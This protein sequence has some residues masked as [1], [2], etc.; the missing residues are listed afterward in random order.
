MPP[1]INRAAV[2]LEIGET[3]RELAKR[4]TKIDQ[5]SG[6]AL[7]TELRQITLTISPLFARLQRVIDNCRAA[8]GS[9]PNYPAVRRAIQE[10]GD[11]VYDLRNQLGEVHSD[12][13][14]IIQAG[15]I[16]NLDTSVIQRLAR[17][18]QQL[19]LVQFAPYLPP[20]EEDTSL[21]TKEET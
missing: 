8:G 17:I 4:L 18:G 15:D 7:S 13:T 2:T 14:Q 16:E 10:G 5:F 21:P 20:I 9:Y 6:D 11:K 3:L 12:L 19:K 1:R